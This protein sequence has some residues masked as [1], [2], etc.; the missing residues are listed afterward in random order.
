M[1]KIC[2]S[3]VCGR[4]TCTHLAIC[5]PLCHSIMNEGSDNRSVN[6][7]LCASRWKRTCVR[8]GGGD[9]NKGSARIGRKISTAK[10]NSASFL[11]FAPVDFGAFST[12]S[13]NHS[14]RRRGFAQSLFSRFARKSLTI[15]IKA[16]RK[17][18]VVCFRV[19]FLHG[20][21]Y[22]S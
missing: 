6:R 17:H 12:R 4:M 19:V 13:V 1:R 18:I 16:D 2:S 20:I 11:F 14:P 5:V 10:R 8:L 3:S 22:S 7:R 21:G 9:E 15:L